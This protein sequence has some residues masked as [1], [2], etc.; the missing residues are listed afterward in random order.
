M[1]NIVFNEI[2]TQMKP[3]IGSGLVAVADKDER[4]GPKE[5]ISN[6]EAHMTR[7]GAK[8]VK[9]PHAVIHELKRTD[10]SCGY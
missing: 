5:R 6:I 9:N 8:Q 10:A 2:G 3:P 7:G 4:E 1:W